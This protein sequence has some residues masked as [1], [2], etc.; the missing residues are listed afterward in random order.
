M[1]DLDPDVVKIDREVVRRSPG[2]EGHADVCRAI[3]AYAR[4]RGRT[5]LA[6]GIETEAE[7]D[8]M[9]SLGVDLLQGFYFGRPA[10]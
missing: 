4:K 5:V 9:R 7:A 10:P 6:E 3:V 2:S 8:L 1:A